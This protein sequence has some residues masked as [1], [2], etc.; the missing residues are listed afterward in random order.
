MALDSNI[1]RIRGTPVTAAPKEYQRWTGTI[2][3]VLFFDALS[4]ALSTGDLVRGVEQCH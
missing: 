2:E 4:T 1:L 3:H